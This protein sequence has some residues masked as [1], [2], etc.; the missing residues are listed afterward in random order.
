[1]RLARWV[2]HQCTPLEMG[3][4]LCSSA[5]FLHN[6]WKSR[7]TWS[8][9]SPRRWKASSA[10][11]SL[12]VLSSPS[13]CLH[14]APGAHISTLLLT[15]HSGYLHLPPGAC[16]LPLSRW[17]QPG[18]AGRELSQALELRLHHPSGGQHK[19]LVALS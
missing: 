1:M 7:E 15:S 4:S 3:P 8:C 18:S 13:S 19:W 5:A 6:L 16:I 14:L 17:A 12:L 2:K 11:I 10:C 9:A